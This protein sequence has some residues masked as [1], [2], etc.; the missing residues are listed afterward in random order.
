M[1]KVALRRVLRQQLRDLSQSFISDASDAVTQRVLAS[2]TWRAATAV[3]VYLPMPGGEV[4]SR[5][6]AMA[7]LR[8]GKSLWVPKVSACRGQG[9]RASSLRTAGPPAD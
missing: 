1:A 9:L 6:L 8:A 7:A 3:S 5:A 4:N 2:P